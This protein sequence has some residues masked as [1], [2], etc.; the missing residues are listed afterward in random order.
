MTDKGAPSTDDE[1]MI[2]LKEWCAENRPELVQLF[3]AILED[4]YMNK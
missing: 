1:A 3:D 4:Y 2:L